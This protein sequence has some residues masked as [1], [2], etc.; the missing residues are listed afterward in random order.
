MA[1]LAISLVQL[2]VPAATPDRSSTG[3]DTAA[4]VAFTWKQPV[5]PDQ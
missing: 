4:V 5:L 1:A 3:S 2:A